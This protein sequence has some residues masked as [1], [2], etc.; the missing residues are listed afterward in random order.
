MGFDEFSKF[1]FFFIIRRRRTGLI[2]NDKESDRCLFGHN[3]IY[4]YL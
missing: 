2:W 4:F 1:V 3:V